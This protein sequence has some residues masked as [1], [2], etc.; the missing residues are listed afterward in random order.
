MTTH[1][2]ALQIFKELTL[3][4]VL[5][6]NMSPCVDNFRRAKRVNAPILDTVAI[7]VAAN[8]KKRGSTKRVDGRSL[9]RVVESDSQ[10]VDGGVIGPCSVDR[11]TSIGAYV[12]MREHKSL[13]GRIERFGYS[14][15]L[16]H[17]FEEWTVGVEQAESGL[18]LGPDTLEK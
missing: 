6:L 5:R 10:L 14:K 12:M 7:E 17:V 3:E 11:D 18:C 4:I 8:Y 15:T 13:R 9:D 1:E 16:R 2:I